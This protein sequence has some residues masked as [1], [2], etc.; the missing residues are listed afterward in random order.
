MLNY[1][2]SVIVAN[3]DTSFVRDA[4]TCFDNYCS[5]LTGT[6]K[7]GLDALLQSIHLSSGFEGQ[8]RQNLENVLGGLA[9]RTSEY[10]TFALDL[11]GKA[12]SITKDPE[13]PQ[14]QLNA[15]VDNWNNSINVIDSAI[16]NGISGYDDYCYL[17]NSRLKVEAFTFSIA[18]GYACDSDGNNKRDFYEYHS[19]PDTGASQF[20][21]SSGCMLLS[22]LFSCSTQ[23]SGIESDFPKTFSAYV[24]KFCSNA[25]LNDSSVLLGS[26]SSDVEK[27]TDG[28]NDV[29]L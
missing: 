20:I 1:R 25:N 9:A 23:S 19:I 14:S 4:V 2:N 17:T 28:D 12:D 29:K 15:T 7:Y 5:N 16:N 10:A 3:T 21:G 6:Q 24:N 22:N 13:N 18:V 27:M 8:A 26:W 11:I